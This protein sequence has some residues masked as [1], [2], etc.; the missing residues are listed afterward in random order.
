MLYRSFL[1]AALLL[2]PALDAVAQ[3]PPCGNLDVP[4]TVI[5]ANGEPVQGLTAADFTGLLKKQ[6]LSIQSLTNDA[7][8]RRILIVIDTVKLLS[9]QARKAQVEFASAV[10]D[11]AQPEDTFALLTAR[12]FSQQAK[13]GA[14]RSALKNALRVLDEHAGEATGD[15][16]QPG[17]MDAV[18][19]GITWFGEPRLGD[20][21]VLLAADLE[22]NHKANHK[23]VAKMLEEHRIRLFGVAFGHLLLTNS[24]GSATGMGREGFGYQQPGIPMY[25]NATGEANFLPLSVNSGGYIVSEDALRGKKEFQLTDLKRKQLQKTGALMAELIDKFYRLRIQLPALSH[26]EPWTVTLKQSQPG[27]HVLY[28]HELSCRTTAPG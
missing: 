13:F 2:I 20:S 5:R 26:P 1:S 14:D 24:T 23:S 3:Q 27:T 17:V 10:V 12:G 7:G 15:A 19:E 16:K 21:I 28:P 9:A 8:P 4:V 11:A 18:A 25:T 6:P 22:G